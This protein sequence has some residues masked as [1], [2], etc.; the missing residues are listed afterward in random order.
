MKL[1]FIR[2]GDPDYLSDS[3]TER[4]F[5]EAELLADYLKDTGFKP[6]KC[7]VS[8][9]GRAKATADV[10]LKKLGMEAETKDW[11]REFQAPIYRPDVKERRSIPW[12]FLPADWT[13]DDRFYS[14]EHWADN[15][16][17]Q[18]GKVGE[19]YR[20]V[21]GAFDELLSF[22]GYVH[23]GRIFR[24]ERANEDTLVFFCHFG[25]TGVLLSHLFHVSPMILLHSM[26]AAPSAVTK[27]VTEER[28]PGIAYFRMVSFGEVSHL[29]AAGVSPSVSGRFCETYERSETMGARRD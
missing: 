11:L 20:R 23:D 21:T 8:P 10:V 9:L 25:V 17:M 2:H 27:V 18:E 1:V 19:E 24:A 14:Y 16:L 15:E 12:D 13:A 4:G 7:Y 3:L 28:R 6:D 22:H 26:I 29:T 5:K